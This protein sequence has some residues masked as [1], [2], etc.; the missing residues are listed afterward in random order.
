M[1]YCESCGEVIC[2]KCC[3]KGNK[4]HDHNYCEF[5]EAFEKYKEEITSLLERMEKQE[6]AMKEALARLDT[7]WRDRTH[8]SSY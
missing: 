8:A 6:A 4:D 2:Y 5:K 1:L 7:L 3:L